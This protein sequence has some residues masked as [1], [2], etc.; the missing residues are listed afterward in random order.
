MSTPIYLMQQQLRS[1]PFYASPSPLATPLG[2]ITEPKIGD[3]GLTRISGFV[4]KMIRIGQWLNGVSWEQA[5]YEH[6]L[7]YLGDGMAI[8]A[9]PGGAWIYP[10][11]REWQPGEILWVRITDLT[12][13]QQA[14]LI[15]EADKLKGTPYS[16]LDYVALMVRRF[17]I[18]FPG[19]KK[20]VANTK[21]MICSQLVD[22]LYH[23]AGIELFEGRWP[24]YVIPADFYIH[25]AS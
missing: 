6:S 25:Y 19:L 24:G 16:F 5:Q 14:A 18:P 23:R 3:V 2:G 9:Q 8:E 1:S 4:G 11:E 13:E 22:E 12:A 10:V 7:L 20:Y 21:H 17:G 15:R